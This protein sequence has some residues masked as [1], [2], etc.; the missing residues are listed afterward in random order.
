[1]QTNTERRFSPLGWSLLLLTVTTGMV[2]AVSFMGLGRVFTALMTGNVAFLGFA[3][4]G[5]EG[6][7]PARSLAALA[8]FA[9]GAL[10]GGRLAA[11]MRTAT[12]RRW[13]TWAAVF[14]VSF[15]VAAVV[16]ALEFDYRAGTP[17]WS[18]YG[19]IVG[20]AVAMGVR[21]ATVLRLADP[22]L[23]TTVLTLTIAGIAADSRLA[24][25]AGARAGRRLAAVLALLLGAAIG[26]YTLR[27]V[28]AWLPLALAA[29]LTAGATALYVSHSDARTIGWGKPGASR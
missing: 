15:M 13:L 19:I 8:A 29:G 6:V 20:T 18:I 12:H 3:L 17:L 1:M 9:L 26:G 27:T 28:G 2:D 24:G 25:G 21:T 7:S 23:K 16:C 5:A 4:A 22:D 11:A 14:E 10:A